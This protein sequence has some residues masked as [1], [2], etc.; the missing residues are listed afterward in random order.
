MDDPLNR[1]FA[2]AA[3]RRNK[4]PPNDIAEHPARHM[5]DL[6]GELESLRVQLLATMTS[7]FFDEG[8]RSEIIPIVKHIASELGTVKVIARKREPAYEAVASVEVRTDRD[9]SDARHE[10]G[11]YQVR[12]KLAM[13]AVDAA[14]PV[15]GDLVFAVHEIDGQLRIDTPDLTE[16][17]AQAIREVGKPG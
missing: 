5:R 2:E 15:R 7:P 4:V 10:A 17:I 11:R 16:K 13:A 9:A 3:P 6:G 8:A 14:G 12:A 1:A